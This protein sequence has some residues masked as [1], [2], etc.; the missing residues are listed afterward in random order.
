MPSDSGNSGTSGEG[1]R[2]H[3]ARWQAWTPGIHGPDDWRAWLDGALAPDPDVRPDAD[4]LPPLLRRRLDLLGRMALHTAWPCAEGLDT[5]EFVFGSRHGSLN[6]TLDMLIALIRHE[7]VS[8]S[9][10]SLAVH[11]NVAGLFSIARGNRG[12]AT[13]IAAGEDS[14]A[15]CL[16]EAAGIIAEGAPHVVVTYADDRVPEVYRTLVPPP[17]SHPFAV[18]LL[19]VPP[20]TAVG[21][22]ALVQSDEATNEEPEVALIRFLTRGAPTASIGVNQHWR[23]ERSADAAS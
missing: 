22:C 14:L 3:I 6:R 15:M 2:F 12:A 4:Y 16:V 1:G 18:S 8:P 20:D 9:L 23:L 13:A 10:F 5:F 17:D 7:P 21:G 11:N 19:L